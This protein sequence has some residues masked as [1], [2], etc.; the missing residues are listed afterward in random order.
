MDVLCIPH[1]TSRPVLCGHARWT[2]GGLKS[3]PVRAD[4]H[5]LTPPERSTT[6]GRCQP[7]AIRSR[8]A[9]VTWGSRSKP[10]G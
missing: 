8:I 10:V 9:A 7:E 2:N 1:R 6:P 4:K 3:E 5:A